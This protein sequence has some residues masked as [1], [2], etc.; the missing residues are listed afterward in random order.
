M[1]RWY[2]R[3]PRQMLHRSEFDREAPRLRHSRTIRPAEARPILNAGTAGGIR[4]DGEHGYDREAGIFQQLAD[5]EFE[6]V[7]G[8]L[9]RWSVEA[10]KRE[11]GPARRFNAPRFT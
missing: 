7:H 1:S 9:E 5:G 2:C 3:P 10:L 11:V 6:V 4:P 8:S